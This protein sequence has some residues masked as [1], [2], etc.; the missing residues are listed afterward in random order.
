MTS[1]ESAEEV[2]AAEP[3]AERDPVSQSAAD[4]RQSPRMGR[5]LDT[6]G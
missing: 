1:D 5:R 3:P 4:I 2:L 6:W